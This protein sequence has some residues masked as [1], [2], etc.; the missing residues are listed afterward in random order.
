MTFGEAGT[1]RTA[2]GSGLIHHGMQK[3]NLDSVTLAWIFN[4]YLSSLQIQ[5]FVSPPER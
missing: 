2:I 3:V 1:A 5:T 4:L